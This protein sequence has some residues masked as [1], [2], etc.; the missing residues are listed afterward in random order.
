MKGVHRLLSKALP[1]T[2]AVAAVLAPVTAL[3][4]N[5]AP[6]QPNLS[7]YAPPWVGFFFMVVLLAIVLGVSLLPSK[8]GHQD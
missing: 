3:A 6:P 7:R 8:R 1:A 5:A 4:Q 2:F